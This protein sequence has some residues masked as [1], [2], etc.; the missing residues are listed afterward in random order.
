MIRLPIID[1]DNP[2]RSLSKLSE[3]EKERGIVALNESLKRSKMTDKN[4]IKKALYKEKPIAHRIINNSDIAT[5]MAAISTG[6]VHFKI[7]KSDAIGANLQEQMEAQFL[8]RW[9][10]NFTPKN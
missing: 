3:Q 6:T 10:G 9:I 7:P 2:P 4:E 5:Y 1:N 8:I